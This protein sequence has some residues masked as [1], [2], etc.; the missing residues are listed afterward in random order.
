MPRSGT[1]LLQD[2]KADGL[3]IESDGEKIGITPAA[4]VTPAIRDEVTR[5]RDEILATLR[6]E[7]AKATTPPPPRT[8]AELNAAWAALRAKREAD[9]ARTSVEAERRRERARFER[10]QALWR[11]ED[12]M[13]RQRRAEVLDDLFG[14]DDG[15]GRGY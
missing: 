1:E 9:H 7:T 14:S 10:A 13:G 11:Y 2:M 15:R 12:A 4:K 8:P 5:H 3:S 6:G